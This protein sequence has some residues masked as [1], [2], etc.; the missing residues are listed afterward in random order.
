M[1]TARRRASAGADP[2]PLVVCSGGPWDGRWHT[3]DDWA[4]ER[5]IAERLRGEGRFGLF[6]PLEYEPTGRD[7]DHPEPARWMPG[8]VWQWTGQLPC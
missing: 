6:R 7:R 2:T 1:T 3:A 5:R 4:N 8:Q